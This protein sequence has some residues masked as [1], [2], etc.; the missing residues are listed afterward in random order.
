MRSLF[1]GTILNPTL[2]GWRKMRS[3]RARFVVVALMV[4]TFAIGMA[5]FLNY[6]KYKTTVGETIKSRV[7]VVTNPIETSVQASLALGLNFAELSILSG[8]LER[9]KA[10]DTLIIGIDVF[11]PS[12]KLLYST[13][14]G[15]VG[16]SAPAKWLDAVRLLNKKDE[17]S[18]EESSQLVTGTALKNNFDLTVGFLAVRYSRAYVDSATGRVAQQLL[19][20]ALP[21]LAIVALLAPLALML[22]MRQFDKDMAAVQDALDRDQ[23]AAGPFGEAVAQMKLNLHQAEQGLGSAQSE[24]ARLT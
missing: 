5:T 14:T 18:V 2:S 3:T 1:P 13:D 7:L 15:R 12:G 24:L 21:V 16:Q 4:C 23:P 19:F 10:S 8:L 9:Q 6:F 17:W 22:V 11:D 20:T